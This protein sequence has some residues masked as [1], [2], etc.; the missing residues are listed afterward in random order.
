MNAF[1]TWAKA[2]S[3]GFAV[4]VYHYLMS[5]IRKQEL[6]IRDGELKAEIKEHEDEERKRGDIDP[7]ATIKS[8][9]DRGKKL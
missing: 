6:T 9:I 8:A 4:E 5:K 7:A 3:I 1:W 2:V